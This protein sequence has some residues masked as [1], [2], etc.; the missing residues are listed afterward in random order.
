MEQVR[1]DALDLSRFGTDSFDLTLVF[2][3]MYHLYDEKDQQQA[4]EEAVRVTKP[5]GII[6]VAF[7][8][9]YSCMYT[10]YLSNNFLA[11]MEENY[12]ED[13]Q[14]KH[15]AGQGFTAFDVCEFENLFSEKGITQV[16]TVST[17]SVLEMVESKS[18]FGLSDE[19]F[20]AFYQYHLMT[21]EKR[22]L[23]GSSN[24][25]LYIGRKK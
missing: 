11:G 12:T 5:Q 7:L 6:M 8:P 4:I 25:L 10:N 2:G 18:D 20:E 9:I 3:P 21:C 23:L 13:Y 1:G 22:E 17:D 24:H 15:F 16:T 14:V 19:D